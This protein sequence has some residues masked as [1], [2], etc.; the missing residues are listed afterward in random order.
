MFKS[1]LIAFLASAIFWG[2]L[3]PS[4]AQLIFDFQEI[5]GHV[6]MTSSG[7]INTAGLVPVGPFDWIGTGIEENGEYDVMG[8]TNFAVINLSFAFNPGTNFSAWRTIGGPWDLTDLDAEIIG[9]N[10]SFATYVLDV[11][12]LEV[13][14]GLGINSDDLVGTLWTTNQSWRFNNQSFESLS[15]RQGTY[16]VTDAVTG[17]SI[18]FFIGTG[19]PEPHGGLLLVLGL[20]IGGLYRRRAV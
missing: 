4:Q 19:I 6:V 17:A 3:V 12:L 5:G 18:T 15:M 8:G 11:D 9:G 20:A 16:I 7:T 1:T 14:P 2:P 13:L 10:R